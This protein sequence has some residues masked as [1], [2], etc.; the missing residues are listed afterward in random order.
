MF[1]RVNSNFFLNVSRFKGSER[2]KAGKHCSIA[3][4]TSI[5]QARI[6][7]HVALWCGFPHAHCFRW[8]VLIHQISGGFI[9]TSQ[10]DKTSLCKQRKE[11]YSKRRTHVFMGN[12]GRA[13]GVCSWRSSQSLF[14]QVQYKGYPS[15]TFA[16]KKTVYHQ[17]GICSQRGRVNKVCICWNEKK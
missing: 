1:L 13:G 15:I 9:T 12:P 5:K 4:N 16:D 17:K 2:R 10:S 11:Q 14:T 3:A 7:F 8:V 6:N